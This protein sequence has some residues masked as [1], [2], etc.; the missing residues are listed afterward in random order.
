MKTLIIW[1]STLF[2]AFHATLLARANDLRGPSNYTTAEIWIQHPNKTP[3]EKLRVSDPHKVA[4]LAAHFPGIL[5]QRGAGPRTPPGEKGTITILFHDKIGDQ[6][7]MRVAHLSAD[8][9][10][11]HWRDNPPFTGA[12]PVEDKDTLRKLLDALAAAAKPSPKTP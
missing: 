10:S 7:Q 3:A 2:L 12:R 4:E 6:A 5:G 9:T 1:L 11:W 8:L